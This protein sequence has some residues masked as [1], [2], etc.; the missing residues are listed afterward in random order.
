MTAKL[1]TLARVTAETAAELREWLAKHHRQSASVWIVTYKK[2]A[3]RPH[4]PWSDLVDEALCFGW[5]DS[6]PRKLDR[7][8]TLHL[9]S[10]RK[11]GSAWSAVNKAKV[12]SL[13]AAGR[14]TQ[15]GLAKIDAAKKD[16][17]WTRIDAAHALAIP[18][19]LAAAF[20]PDPVAAANFAAFAPS[21]RRAILE[22]IALAKR[23]ETRAK[24]V[25][26]TARLA[27]QNRKA[28]HP[29]GRDQGVLSTKK[30]R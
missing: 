22:W 6:L 23:P 19:D 18:A 9:L 14:M 3:S 13:V 25:A 20:A 11:A 12:E 2:G 17:S 10:P 7:E 4:L 21:S 8:R 16:G 29:A 5:I 26:E 24:R 28:N 1:D 30:A 15:A 27:G